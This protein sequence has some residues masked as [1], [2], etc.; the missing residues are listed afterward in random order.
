LLCWQAFCILKENN[1]LKTSKEAARMKSKDKFMTPLDILGMQL[2]I[3]EEFEKGPVY[4]HGTHLRPVCSFMTI[5]EILKK[6]QERE[7]DGFP[8][9]LKYRRVLTPSGKVVTVPYIEEEKLIHGEFEP[10]KMELAQA[11]DEE[12]EDLG[13]TTGH[14]E[15]EVGDVIGEVPIIGENDGDEGP[16]PGSEPGVHEEEIYETG[17]KLIEKFQLPHL[18]E[19]NKKVPTDEYIY[20]LTD[21]H[22]G[23]GQV[24]DK[25]E[26]LKRVLETNI[27]LGRADKDDIDPKKFIIRPQD[28]IFRVLSK[29]RVFKSQA[30]VFFMRDYSGSMWGEP[31]RVI[32]EQHLMIYGWLMAEY[33]RLVVPRFIVHDTEA[34]EVK[35]EDYFRKSTAGGT[36]IA[37][38]YKKI[39]EIVETE[40]LA[41]DYNIYLFQGTDGEDFDDGKQAIP[42]I[43][44]IL[45]YVNRLGVCVLQHPY[46]GGDRKSKFEQYIEKGNFLSKKELFRI[47]VVPSIDVTNMTEEKQIEAIKAL[48]A[49]D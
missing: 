19:K 29:E 6:D 21:R 4:K 34:Q 3:T 24:L 30:V 16:E 7:K 32:V 33:E 47:H 10:K 40:G 26:T 37:S 39:N 28:K 38:G 15:G 2:K 36:L 42:E 8:K 17:K 12:D 27:L 25:K 11:S 49:Q 13:T 22:E 45:G 31:T 23:S 20:D 46:Y 43:K 44:K 14:G 9:K 48:L 1:S 41:R 18:K 35:V 5:E